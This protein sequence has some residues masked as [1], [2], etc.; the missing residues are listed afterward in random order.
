MSDLPIVAPGYE[1]DAPE[2][3]DLSGCLANVCILNQAVLTETIRAAMNRPVFRVLR[4]AEPVLA[5]LC[6]G[7]LIWAVS[8]SQ[9]RY[10]IWCGFLLVM[11]V[12]FY[13]QQFLLYPKKAV[14]N[15]L[16]R[17]ALDDGAAELVN[18]LYFTE[19]NVANRRGDSDQLLHMDY[20][21]IKQITETRN[22]LILTTKRNRLI[23]LD[24]G[25]FEN[26][27]AEDLRKL[28]QQ[29]TEIRA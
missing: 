8:D 2:A 3:E 23:P 29:K 27:S 1:E 14:K 19:K 26:G 25:G 18:R 24:K 6:L 10:A 13:V 22:L 15:Q 9:L 5:L 7:L 12:F 4:I 16:R 20:D 28:L 11:L 17:Q 21:K